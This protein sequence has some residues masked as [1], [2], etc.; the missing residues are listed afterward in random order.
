MCLSSFHQICFLDKLNL[1]I[2]VHFLLNT[3]LILFDG[4]N[5]FLVQDRQKGEP[6]A[7]GAII[8]VSLHNMSLLI[9]S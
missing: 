8:K 4:K 5:L 7:L 1:R 9:L 2:K 6:A 3:H